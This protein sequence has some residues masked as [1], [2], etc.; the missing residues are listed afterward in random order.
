[1]KYNKEKKASAMAF[2]KILLIILG[3]VVLILA[4]FML[5]NSNILGWIKN[6]PGASS[7]S[8]SI[9][10][11]SVSEKVTLGYQA[12]GF[13]NKEIERK[14]FSGGKERY[15][16]FCRDMFSC[17]TRTESAIYFSAASGKE[18]TNGKLYLPINWGL[19]EQIGEVIE[20]R[21]KISIS[22][23][24]YNA[25]KSENSKNS[26]IFPDYSLLERLHNSK[27]INGFFYKSNSELTK[28]LED[29]NKRIET[30]S[31]GFSKQIE[32]TFTEGDND[33]V[34]AKWN[35]DKGYVEVLIYANGNPITSGD[36]VGWIN[37]TGYENCLNSEIIT[38][39]LYV[40]QIND[41]KSII[42]S[43]SA[44]DFSESLFNLLKNENVEITN[45][46]K[47]STLAVINNEL[48][49]VDYLPSDVEIKYISE[50]SSQITGEVPNIA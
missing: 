7:V 35:F 49:G 19:D 40:S 13:L 24:E 48:Y 4:V 23:S 30:L 31:K 25:L 21:L 32:I 37:P 5:T 1:M 44:K 41:I 29:Y 12:V 10:E 46:K 9:K 36:C 33:L 38:K 50:S 27:F 14:Y 47:D 43:P 34:Y 17:S 6:L 45:L 16:D 39:N 18:G 11:L 28:E 8:D 2:D 3:I 42:L 22:S 15:I 20:S 26:K